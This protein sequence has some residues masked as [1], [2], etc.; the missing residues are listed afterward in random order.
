MAR[1]FLLVPL[2]LLSG[3]SHFGYYAHAIQGQLELS[4][5]AIPLPQV[6]ADAGTDPVVARQLKRAQAAREFASR[7]LHL[8][9]NGSFRGYADL[10]RPF[11]LW[12]VFATPELSVEPVT[13]CFPVAG[14]V[15]YR[16]YFSE[17][18]A[19]EEAAALAARGLDVYVAGIP[20]YSTLGW[21]DDPL[22]NTF[23]HYPEAE[24]VGLI[25][26]ELAHQ[27]VYVPGDSAFNEAFASVVEEE[28]V[29]RW[30]ARQGEAGALAR[31]QQGRERK[32]AFQALL[33]RTRDRLA[34][35]YAA[36]PD[37]DAARTAK[38]A[39]LREAEREYES[40]RAAWG[41]YT[42]YD[43][44]FRST[45]LNNAKLTSVTL[46]ADQV[47]ALRALLAQVD[48]DLPR[49]YQA[50]RRLG[51]LAPEARATALA[52]LARGETGDF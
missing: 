7:E 21:F 19:R 27:V 3:C 49:F 50:A 26:H 32:Q 10:G 25:F 6:L 24:L 51:H 42:G 35:A 43:R 13:W 44:W 47:P 1:L 45:P 34:A 14:C 38:A 20:V 22:L 48:Y 28:G 29:K 31:W 17:E 36:A 12:N 39:I 9:D 5:R 46:Y 11:A 18:A 4:R 2:L 30:F 41:G 16:G 37:I 33:Q 8:P 15:A 52:R 23:I 40:L